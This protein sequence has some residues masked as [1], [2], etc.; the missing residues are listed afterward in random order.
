MCMGNADKCIYHSVLKHA[1]F[2]AYLIDE[3]DDFNGNHWETIALF[4]ERK[5]NLWMDKKEHGWQ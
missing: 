1:I 2:Q 5:W 3:D 4:I